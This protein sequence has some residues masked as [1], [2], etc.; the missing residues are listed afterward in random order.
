MSYR[1]SAD[2][3]EME[4]MSGGEYAIKLE[5]SGQIT[6]YLAVDVTNIDATDILIKTLALPMVSKVSVF[7]MMRDR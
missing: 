4:I 3:N 7:T 1:T 6:R 5:E 2:Y